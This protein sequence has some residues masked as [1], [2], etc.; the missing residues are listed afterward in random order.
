LI[1]GLNRKTATHPALGT[2]PTVSCIT[3]M[4]VAVQE[5]STVT[6]SKQI[7]V[8]LLGFGRHER[9][10]LRALFLLSNSPARTIGYTEWDESAVKGADVMLVDGDNKAAVAT[11]KALYSDKAGTTV[12][13]GSHDSDLPG[14]LVRKPLSLKVV[15]ALD[16]AAG[17]MR[18]PRTPTRKRLLI[19]RHGPGA[20]TRG[21]SWAR[22]HYPGAKIHIFDVGKHGPPPPQ[23][24]WGLV[25]VILVEDGYARRDGLLWLSELRSRP[26]FPRIE[27]FPSPELPQELSKLRARRQNDEEAARNID[28]HIE[29]R[30][31]EEAALLLQSAGI[32]GFKALEVI[33]KGA[34]STVC[35]CERTTDGARVALKILTANEEFDPKALPRF[36]QECTLTVSLDSPHVARVFEHG[37]TASHA[38]LAMEHFSGGDLRSRLIR[39]KLLEEQAVMLTAALL[40][41][42][43]VVHNAGI[44]HRDIKPANI[45]FRSNGT[46]ALTDFGSAMTIADGLADIQDGVVIGTPYYLSPEQA[47]GGAIDTRSDLYSV[48]ALFYELLTGEKIF[49]G[50]SVAALLEQHQTHPAPRL[51]STVAHYQSFLDRLTAKN[52]AERFPNAFDALHSLMNAVPASDDQEACAS[53]A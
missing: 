1:N 40:D 10:A 41:A 39:G 29:T 28:R 8:H 43:I 23:F 15:G 33:G 30:K 22:Q 18:R 35:L 16:R 4:H 52:P 19:L 17:A 48:G 37:A 46:L 24:R 2:A 13:A 42:L 7:T 44:V 5:H 49:A 31:A 11:W 38:Y 36:V 9:R 12:F 6:R 27:R 50:D 3:H 26:G 21:R 20:T 25:S 45:M 14:E 32:T 53:V 47:A 51:P 34:T